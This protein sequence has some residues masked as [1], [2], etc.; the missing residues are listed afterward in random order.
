MQHGN[1]DVVTRR[2]IEE[3]NF[4]DHIWIQTGSNANQRVPYY[5]YNDNENISDY[6]ENE[7]VGLYDRLSSAEVLKNN[8]EN[9]YTPLAK[10]NLKS[11][12]DFVRLRNLFPQ[13]YDNGSI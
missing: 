8:E 11:S 13:V 1:H 5:R 2:A 6:Y 12:V 10:E 3:A 9:S 4:T 7:L